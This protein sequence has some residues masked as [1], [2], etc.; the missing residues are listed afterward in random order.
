[1]VY[2]EGS[3]PGFPIVGGH[4]GAPPILPFFPKTPT[5]SKPMPP[6]GVHP[7]LKN[8]APPSEKQLPP[9]LKREAPMKW[10]LEKV[11]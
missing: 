11:Q 4:G 9:T 3:C 8:K 5:P 7:L 6:Y 10:F 1:M 2:G